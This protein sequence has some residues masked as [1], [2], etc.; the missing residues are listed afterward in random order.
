MNS[1]VCI[2]LETS[3][4]SPKH[5]KIIEIGAV[6]IIDGIKTDTFSSYINPGR[7]L[8][9]RITELTGIK[10][11]DLENAPSIDKVI[12]QIISFIGDLPLLGHRIIFD[13]SFLK[14]AAV[15][16]GLSFD[17]EGVDTLKISRV[18]FPELPSKR[19]TD[20]CKYYSI[21]LDAHKAFNDAMATVSLYDCLKRDFEDKYPE[22][23]KKTKLIYNVKKETPIRPGQIEKLS[24]LI[25]RHGIDCPYDLT[26]MSRNEASRYYDVLRAKYGNV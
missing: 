19:L 9:E 22:Q 7:K 14:Q 3:G 21:T 16:A 12:N 5:D 10:E 24:A 13:F 23:F 15:N 25:E 8:D 18:C 6:K 2:D 20:M 11:S 4:L 1:F 17:K 26:K